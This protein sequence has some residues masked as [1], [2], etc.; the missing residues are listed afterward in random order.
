MLSKKKKLNS[1]LTLHLLIVLDK[2]S[3]IGLLLI[4]FFVTRSE[5]NSLFK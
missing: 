4:V 1:R 2:L 5:T 3:Y